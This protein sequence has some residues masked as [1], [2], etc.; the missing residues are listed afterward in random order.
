MSYYNTPWPQ[1]ILE[2]Y[3]LLYNIFG[4]ATMPF[5]C[6]GI[7]LI[8]GSLPRVNQVFILKLAKVHLIYAI[9][10][11]PYFNFLNFYGGRSSLAF[12]NFLIL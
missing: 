5:L 10:L 11:I 3:Q 7:V 1:I 6:N 4:M 12:D 8:Q 9:F 2:L